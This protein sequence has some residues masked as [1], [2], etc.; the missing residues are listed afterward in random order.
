MT[1][2]VIELHRRCSSSASRVRVF[3]AAHQ[4]SLCTVNWGV[5]L[6]IQRRLDSSFCRTVPTNYVEI[7]LIIRGLVFS[8]SWHLHCSL[9]LQIYQWRYFY[10]ESFSVSSELGVDQFARWSCDCRC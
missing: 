4:E 2:R 3:R 1:G 8:G 6:P 10:E 7:I 9:K 5:A